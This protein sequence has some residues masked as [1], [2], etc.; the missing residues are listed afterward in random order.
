ML[1]LLGWKTAL[2]HM[3]IQ[4]P[5]LRTL[6]TSASSWKLK[7]M[8]KTIYLLLDHTGLEVTHTS[9]TYI[10]LVRTSNLSAWSAKKCCL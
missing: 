1:Q 9:S 6:E 8:M 5:R 10:L 2:L 3:V 7:E 4:G